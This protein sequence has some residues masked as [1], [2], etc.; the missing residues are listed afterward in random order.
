[1]NRR[2]NNHPGLVPH[3]D[4]FGAA[5]GFFGVDGAAGGHYLFLVALKCLCE[6][7]Y[8][9]VTHEELRKGKILQLRKECL[10]CLE[11]EAVTGV[12]YKGCGGLG[13]VGWV[14]I[15][16]IGASD[17]EQGSLDVFAAEL[18]AL[19]E[20]GDGAEVVRIIDG[21]MRIM[22]EG[23]IEAVGAFPI[24]SAEAGLIEKEKHGGDGYSAGVLGRIEA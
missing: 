24:E 14:K 21:R 12:P 19:D 10:M 4:F 23:Y 3:E 9:G 7:G 1:M 5:F 20:V 16:E 13:C 15:D 18:D 8:I 11:G 17:A 22:S 6:E 2:S